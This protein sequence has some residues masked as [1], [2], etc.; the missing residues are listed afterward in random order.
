MFQDNVQGLTQD[1]VIWFYIND[2]K[3]NEN[4]GREIW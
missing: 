4:E 3:I 2:L 1:A